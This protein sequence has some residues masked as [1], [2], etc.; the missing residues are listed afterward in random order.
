M[1]KTYTG[2]KYGP[3]KTTVP[4]QA[5]GLEANFNPFVQNCTGQ[6]AAMAASNIW[7]ALVVHGAAYPLISAGIENQAMQYSFNE[8]ARKNDVVVYESIPKFISTS[9]GGNRNPSTVLIVIDNGVADYVMINDH[10]E[11]AHGFGYE[12]ERTTAAMFA[13]QRGM[14]LDKDVCLTRPPNHVDK[15]IRDHDDPGNL[16]C[17]GLNANILYA[18]LPHVAQDSFIFRKG[19]IEQCAHH[20]VSTIRI[21]LRPDEIPL[22]LYG[23]HDE[24]KCIPDIG[25][26][27]SAE[28]VL[29]AIR[30]KS[31]DTFATLTAASLQSILYGDDRLV[32]APVGS[33]VVDVQVYFEPKAYRQASA[34]QG[35][36]SQICMYQDMHYRFYDRVCKVYEELLTDGYRISPKL[37]DL[38]TNCMNYRRKAG[39]PLVDDRDPITNCVIDITYSFVRKVGV[40]NKFSGRSGDKGVTGCVWDDEN[41]PVDEFGIRAD[42]IACPSTVSN[43][44]NV[45]QYYEQNINRLA[46]LMQHRLKHGQLGEGL[47]AFERCIEFMRDVHLE[48]GDMINAQ[49]TSDDMR[50]DFV[51]EVINKGFYF[52]IPPFMADMTMEHIDHLRTKYN[53]QRSPV[54]YTYQVAP[55]EMRTFTTQQPMSIGSK[56]MYLLGKIPKMMMSAHEL[57]HINQ[58]KIPIKSDRSIM[59]AQYATA[60]TPIRF[61]EDEI[62]MLSMLHDP[63]ETARFMMMRAGCKAAVDA[64]AE[65]L[66]TCDKP[67]ALER[68]PMG[69][70]DMIRQ[71]ET[72]SL[73]NHMMGVVGVDMRGPKKKLKKSRK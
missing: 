57:T 72:I 17:Q 3:F 41:M 7:Q 68:V 32:Y 63:E 4:V 51:I 27:V 30:R 29:M 38:V 18:T 20:S 22:N 59:K 52:V 2:G 55:G 70:K 69:T 66:L 45:S 43:R 15:N 65:L 56:Y 54:T 12:N 16:Y 39:I 42:M 21:S 11:L 24:P 19:W 73:C 28:G 9:L 37:N 71:S 49:F 13:T 10:T 62:R 34:T 26:S 1:D 40:G 44:L 53:Y 33:R 8:S 36:L 46:S 14:P 67:S 35:L 6:R 61:G 25:Q 31:A 50:R 5:A 58:F 48:Y 60:P 47:E 64:T 23:A